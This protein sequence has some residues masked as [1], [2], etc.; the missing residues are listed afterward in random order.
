ML[1][2]NV[3]FFY[4]CSF[5]FMRRVQLHKQICSQLEPKCK[6]TIITIDSC[7]E[8]LLNVVLFFSFLFWPIC[9]AVIHRNRKAKPKAWKFTSRS[10]H[11]RIW[12]VVREKKKSLIYVPPK[13]MNIEYFNLHVFSFLHEFQFAFSISR[14]K[15]MKNLVVKISISPSLSELIIT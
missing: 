14:Q 12:M 6:W 1:F 2:C 8:L 9:I 4:E 13:S 11:D 15:W 7:V 5:V 10:I 3:S